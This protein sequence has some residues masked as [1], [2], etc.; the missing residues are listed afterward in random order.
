MLNMYKRVKYKPL[1]NK[2]LECVQ[3]YNI[4]NKGFFIYYSSSIA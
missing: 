3:Y 2:T 1:H 4:L